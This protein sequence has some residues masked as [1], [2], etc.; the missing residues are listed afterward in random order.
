MKAGVTKNTR[1]VAGGAQEAKSAQAVV[2]A[3]RPL[4]PAEETEVQA[5]R[6]RI[7]Q[8]PL[9]PRVRASGGGEFANADDTNPVLF[10]ARITGV[11]GST[12]PEAGNLLIGQ[13]AASLTGEDMAATGRDLQSRACPARG[14]AAA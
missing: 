2:A 4:T 11:V 13:A 6:D 10:A 7:R 3:P 12:D 9:A 8:R 5:F 1:R 14:H